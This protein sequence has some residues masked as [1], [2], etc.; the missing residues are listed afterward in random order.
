M[1]SSKLKDVIPP[2]SLPNAKQVTMGAANN[3]FGSK[4]KEKVLVANEQKKS[5]EIKQT[6]VEKKA[7]SK[8]ES[9]NVGQEITT[10]SATD[11]VPTSPDSV[12]INPCILL[13]F[14]VCFGISLIAAV[15]F[16]L[17]KVSP[18]LGSTLKAVTTKIIGNTANPDAHNP[19]VEL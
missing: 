1:S 18:S 15:V 10:I 13:L 19:S 12:P 9:K 8:E 17:T 14:W 4:S 7:K 3:I 11:S 5:A 6:S 2:M 16:I